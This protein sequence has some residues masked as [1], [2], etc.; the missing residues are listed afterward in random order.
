MRGM[1]YGVVFGEE[2]FANRREEGARDEEDE[3]QILQNR[4]QGVQ[5]L[6]AQDL[7]LGVVFLVHVCEETIVTTKMED[8]SI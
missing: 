2:G 1:F 6:Q 5:G 8:F 3:R 7:L 4:I